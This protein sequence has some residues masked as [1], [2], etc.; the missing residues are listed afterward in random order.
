MLCCVSP[1]YNFSRLISILFHSGLIRGS[2][3]APANTSESKKKGIT[4]VKTILNDIS[5]SASPGEIL[6]LMGPSGSGKTS[7][8]DVLS[9]RSAYDGGTITLDG[10][11]VTDK[12]MKK[13]KKRVAYVK[14]NDLFFGHLTV[15]DQ[16]MYTAFL[17]LPSAW[18][19]AQKIGEVDRIIKQVSLIICKSMLLYKLYSVLYTYLICNVSLIWS[20]LK[21]RLEKCADS[22]INMISGGEKKRVNIGSELL[23][24]PSIIILDEPTSG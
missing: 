14:Q 13:L 3:A 9:G 10:E 4:T 17:R 24:D 8:L 22:S 21:L 19:K 20:G 2:I 7:M 6:A 18:S 5:G 23:T 12:V 11:V 1:S 16:L 15:R